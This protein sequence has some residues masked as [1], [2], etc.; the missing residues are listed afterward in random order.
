[1]IRILCAQ[2]AIP[3]VKEQKIGMI[4]LKMMLMQLNI[5]ISIFQNTIIYYQKT[6]KCA[7]LKFLIVE[8]KKILLVNLVTLDIL[9]LNKKKF[10]VN[11]VNQDQVI[12]KLLIME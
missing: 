9:L 2:N 11:N 8:H 1:M 4:T 5:K 10:V 7:I 6:N 3:S 12:D